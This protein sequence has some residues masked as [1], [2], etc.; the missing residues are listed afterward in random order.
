MTTLDDYMM[1]QKMYEFKKGTDLLKVWY[2]VRNLVKGFYFSND[3]V[4]GQEFH[5]SISYLDDMVKN[6]EE[7][8]EKVYREIILREKDD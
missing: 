3:K 7:M 5:D 8:I 4:L 2:H 6:V 1:F